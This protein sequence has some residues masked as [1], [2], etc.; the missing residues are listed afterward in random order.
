MKYQRVY[1]SRYQRP[2]DK[3]VKAE[4]VCGQTLPVLPHY[5]IKSLSIFAEIQEGNHALLH[6]IIAR[7]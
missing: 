3:L 4:E 1:I 7:I 6:W 2:I 5:F